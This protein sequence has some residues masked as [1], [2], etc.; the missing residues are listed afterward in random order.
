M[1]L[2]FI[3]LIV[4]ISSFSFAENSQ[5]LKCRVVN[6][7]WNSVFILDAVGVGFLN[8]SKKGDPTNYS[9]A[10]KIDFIN[11][12][13]RAVVPNVVVE[14]SRVSCSPE[15]SES[16]K[17]VLPRFTLLINVTNK[18]KPEGKVQWLKTKQPNECIVD[19]LSMFDISMNTKKWRDGKWGR[20]ATASDPKNK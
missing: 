8:F 17:E 13:Q 12:G 2:R 20:R 19:K 10:L 15:L 1:K 4:C 18:S 7:V 14:F 11:D 5:I 16:V 9:C 3:A 6:E